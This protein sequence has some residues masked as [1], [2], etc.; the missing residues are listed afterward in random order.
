[1]PQRRESLTKQRVKLD[2]FTVV[3]T[4]PWWAVLVFRRSLVLPPPP[5]S[6]P[7][8]NANTANRQHNTAVWRYCGKDSAVFLFYGHP[9]SRYRRKCITVYRQNSYR[10]MAISR[11]YADP[12][13]VSVV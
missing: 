9:H 5:K 10:H 13:K 3:E 4:P 12:R 8:K 2:I 6:I 7:P 11:K 1:G